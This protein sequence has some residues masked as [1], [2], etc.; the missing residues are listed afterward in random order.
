M[1][2]MPELK[3]QIDK[4]GFAEYEKQAFKHEP[5]NGVFG[6]CYRTCLAGLIGFPRDEVPHFVDG[7]D[8]KHWDEVIF[9]KYTKWLSDLGLQELNLP[10]TANSIQDMLDFQKSMT[11][12]PAVMMLTGKGGSGV[13]HCVLVSDGKF[14]HDPSPSDA[15]IVGPCDDGFYWFTWLIPTDLRFTAFLHSEFV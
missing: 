5:E 7:M 12:M 15:Y 13:G 11:R 10:I 4:H 8:S 6:D 14:V 9:P 3:Q 2:E 1:K